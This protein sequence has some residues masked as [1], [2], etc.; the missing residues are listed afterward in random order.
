MTMLLMAIALVL[1]VLV[2]LSLGVLG[3]GG[4][5]VM[6]PVLV[7]IAGVPPPEAV[8]MSLAVVGATSA[9]GAVVHYRYGNV[10][11]RATAIFAAAGIV[12]AAGGARLTH[13]VPHAAL[14]LLFAML[15]LAAG[16]RMARGP[17]R[18]EQAAGRAACRPWRCGA[19]GL[20]VGALTGFLG[21]GG[22]FLIVPALALFGG[23]SMKQA[24]GSS[25]AVIALNSAAGLASQLQYV[26]LDGLLSL[27]FMAAALVGMLAGSPLAARMSNRGL[28][29]TF[30]WSV[31]ALGVVL[32]AMNLV[33][34]GR[35]VEGVTRAGK[36]TDVASWEADE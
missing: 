10:A 26:A 4:S 23:L 9:A 7:H 34:L 36:V 22:G 32:L 19:A 27:A 35:A 6:L 12:G 16:A 2:G 33:D 13:L 30:A 18:A 29:Q 5:I 24:V 11:T 31:I 28:R 15:L 25:L 20:G 17:T 21:V 14:L 1:A 8:A 3:S